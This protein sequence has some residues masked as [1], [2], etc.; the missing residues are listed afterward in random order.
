MA[1]SLITIK[2]IKVRLLDVIKIE[3]NM[4]IFSPLLFHQ[5]GG[6]FS[7]FF[8]QVYLLIYCFLY[9]VKVTLSLLDAK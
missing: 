9:R 8:A 5:I 1:S 3:P 2:T 6:I 4:K 7:E